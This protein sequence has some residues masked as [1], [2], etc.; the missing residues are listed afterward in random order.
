VETVRL[1]G[2]RMGADAVAWLLPFFPSAFL[3]FIA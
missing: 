2:M 3:L 1:Y